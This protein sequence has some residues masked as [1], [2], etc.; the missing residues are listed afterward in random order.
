[1]TVGTLIYHEWLESIG[2]V[3]D[4]VRN[5]RFV[6]QVFDVATLGTTS[7]VLIPDEDGWIVE[8]ENHDPHERTTVRAGFPHVFET[9]DQ[10]IGLLRLCG[11]DVPGWP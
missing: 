2:F 11:V 9:Q 6:R 3:Q 7:V 4:P 8:L 5:Y 10:V 1:M